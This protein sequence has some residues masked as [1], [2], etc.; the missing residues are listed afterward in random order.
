[1]G[2][3]D[4]PSN[5]IELTIEE[6]AEAHRILFEKYGKVED[7]WA[8]KGLS[9]QIGKDEILRE[10]CKNNGNKRAADDVDEGARKKS[11]TWTKTF[12]VRCKSEKKKKPTYFPMS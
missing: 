12:G 5:L 10:I 3:S 1:M 2:G 8:W 7:L 4:D 9:G 6:H 11:E